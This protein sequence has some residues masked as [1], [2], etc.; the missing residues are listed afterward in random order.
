MKNDDIKFKLNQQIKYYQDYFIPE[1]DYYYNAWING[2]KNHVITHLR[3]FSGEPTFYNII[4][5][6]FSN[7]PELLLKLLK[8]VNEMRGTFIN[9]DYL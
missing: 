7:N 1:K 9:N 6:Q 8:K 3:I 2:N 5:S 4:I